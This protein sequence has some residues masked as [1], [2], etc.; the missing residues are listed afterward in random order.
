MPYGPK[1]IAHVDSLGYVWCISCTS[2]AGDIIH[3]IAADDG[4]ALNCTCDGCSRELPYG[5]GD[6]VELSWSALAKCWA[7]P[8]DLIAFPDDEPMMVGAES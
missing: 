7:D 3:A 5:R 1:T 2:M 8:N 4:E 6:Y